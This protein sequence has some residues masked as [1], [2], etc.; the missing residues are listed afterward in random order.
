MKNKTLK[1]SPKV[2]G[3]DISTK[4]IG[5]ALFDIQ[6]RELLELTHISPVPK[7]KEECKIK[8]LLLKS[9]I[10]KSK[11][12]LYKGL[13]ITKVVI[14]EPLLNSNNIRTVQTLLR[15]NSFVCKI[16]YDTL[17]IVPDFIST[18]ES[19]KNAFPELIKENDKGKFVLFGGLPK[20]IDKK[21]IVW[22]K[23]AKLEPQIN[24]LYTKNNTL[25]KENFDQTDAYCCVLGHMNQLK[26]W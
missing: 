8:E 17:G 13:G 1:E 22:E 18:Y 7:P 9:D 4:T 25:K 3:L 15:F 16:I 2:L 20:D 11:L 19:R 23:I 14:E 6:T 21:M 5:W 10:F 12:E 24:W 26:I